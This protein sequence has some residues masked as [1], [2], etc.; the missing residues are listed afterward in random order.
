MILNFH[1]NLNE[2]T[3]STTVLSVCLT[4]YCV[5]LCFRWQNH[6][7]VCEKAGSVS[8]GRCS[9]W[10]HQG[11]PPEPGPPPPPP[12]PVP[13]HP[14]PVQPDGSVGE[15]LSNR[16][17]T[18]G[19][20]MVAPTNYGTVGQGHTGGGEKAFASVINWPSKSVSVFTCALVCWSCKHLI[21]GY[22][23]SLP[24]LQVCPQLKLRCDWSVKE[25]IVKNAHHKFLELKIK[26][27]DVLFCPNN[28]WKPKYIQFI[29]ILTREKQQILIFEKP[30]SPCLVFASVLLFYLHKSIYAYVRNTFHLFFKMNWLIGH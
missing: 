29:M 3:I 5:C 8:T 27:S 6:A 28:S 7:G 25:K 20:R 9:V 11:C 4:V 30:E 1:V 17:P 12:P 24:C 2:L 18:Q 22:D 15:G 19:G 21:Q 16:D 13:R 26:S 23:H 10:P 14:H